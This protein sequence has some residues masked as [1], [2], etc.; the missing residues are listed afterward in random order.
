MILR[1]Y[2]VKLLISRLHHS[3]SF[4]LY[5]L[6]ATISGT[7]CYF[8]VS[9]NYVILKIKRDKAVERMWEEA[10]DNFEIILLELYLK[11]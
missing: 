10:K 8:K 11:K 5:L 3:G 4:T 9:W 1:N 6:K 2:S 7:L